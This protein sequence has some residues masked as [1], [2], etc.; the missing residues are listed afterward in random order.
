MRPDERR[1]EEKQ[2]KKKNGRKV[3]NCRE[4]KFRG[5]NNAFG[6]NNCTCS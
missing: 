2:K 4:E 6:L 5:I 1:A 3:K